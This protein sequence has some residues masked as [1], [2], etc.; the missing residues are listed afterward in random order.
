MSTENKQS[1]NERKSFP[2]PA[3]PNHPGL[4]GKN[5][6]TE[7]TVSV[8]PLLT[9]DELCDLLKV[10]P[11]TIYQLTYRGK[12]PHYKI[13]NKLRFRQSEILFWIEDHRITKTLE[14]RPEQGD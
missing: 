4:R 14:S 10:E 13:A 9:M 1:K 11:A 2:L 6:S 12:I 5:L 3:R 8:D 7:K